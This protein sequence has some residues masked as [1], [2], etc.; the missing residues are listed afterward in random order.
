MAPSAGIIAVS[1]IF[2]VGIGGRHE[3]R[4]SEAAVSYCTAS[5][6]PATIGDSAH[7]PAKNC[8]ARSAL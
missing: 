3:L 6:W 2:S 4:V 7:H 8:S 1:F 5:V